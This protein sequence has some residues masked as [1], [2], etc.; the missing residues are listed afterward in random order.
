MTFADSIPGKGIVRGAL[1][2]T[3]D[4]LAL[5]HTHVSARQQMLMLIVNFLAGIVTSANEI[6]GA[7]DN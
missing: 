6:E 7:D 4:N 5:N 3:F 1:C 2:S